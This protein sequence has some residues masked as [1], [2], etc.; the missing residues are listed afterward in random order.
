MVS[1]RGRPGTDSPIRGSSSAG[2]DTTRVFQKLRVRLFRL[3]V[4]VRGVGRSGSDLSS[5]GASLTIEV[6]GIVG[7]G[8]FVALLTLRSRA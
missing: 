1:L 6:R 8:V 3:L 5:C 4:F 2:E 7:E